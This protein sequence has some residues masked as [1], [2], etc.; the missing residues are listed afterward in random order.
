MKANSADQPRLI[1]QLLP[2]DQGFTL[3]EVLVAMAVLMV[4]ILGVALAFQPSSGTAGGADFGIAAVSRANSYST[5]TEL[6]QARLEEVKN[7]RYTSTGPVDQITS[8]NFPAEAYGAIAG[9]A[10]FRRTVTIQNGT[11]AAGMKT[12]SVQVFFTPQYQT[13][14]GSEEA[15]QVSTLIAQRP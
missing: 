2:Q 4:G 5:A 11:P 14:R 12:I 15:V 1:R 10:G 7:G 6:A 3:V 9:Y 8:A 13:R